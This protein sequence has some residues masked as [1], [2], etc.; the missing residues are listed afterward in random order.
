[1]TIIHNYRDFQKQVGWMMFDDFDEVAIKP[2]TF[3]GIFSKKR[4]NELIKFC[5]ENPQYHIVSEKKFCCFNRIIDDAPIYFLGKGSHCPA[6]MYIPQFNSNDIYNLKL[7]E[8]D[9]G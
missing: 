4:L 5:N 2:C 9:I 1:M 8:F 3:M 6:L 7:L